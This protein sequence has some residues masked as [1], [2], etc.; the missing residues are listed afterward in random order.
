[1]TRFA[2]G[3]R[4]ISTFLPDW[5]DGNGPG[6]ARDPNGRTLG[7]PMQG[8]WPNM[9]CCTRTGRFGRPTR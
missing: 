2:A 3:D 5:I 4:V 7:G 1:V 8:V 6:T 9:S